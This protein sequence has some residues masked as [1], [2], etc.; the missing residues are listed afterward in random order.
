MNELLLVRH[1]ASAGQDPNA[2]LSNEGFVQAARLAESLERF[3]VDHIASSPFRRA[4]QTIAPFAAATGLRVDAD[5]R[6][7][8]RTL[9]AEPLDDWRE[10]LRHTWLDFDYRAAGGET[11]R[12]A[13]E[14]GRSALEEVAAAGHRCAVIVSH[15]NLLG[16][17][18]NSID[19]GFDFDAWERLTNP[20]VFRLR[21][22]DGSYS[23]E[24]VW[25]EDG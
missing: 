21:A 23:V 12:E 8:E 6:L 22:V 1:C 14:R 16:L 20:D 18:L 2:P 5:V 11:S 3:A 9:S 4:L 15:G 24:R 17:I 13:Q 25:R 10:Q 19:P 7:A